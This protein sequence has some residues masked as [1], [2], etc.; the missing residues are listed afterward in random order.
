MEAYLNLFEEVIRS[1]ADTVG[2]EVALAQAKK[3]GLGVSREG[4]IVSC[5]GNPQLVL[6]RLIRS[7]TEGG[8]V[9]SLMACRPLIDEILANPPVEQPDEV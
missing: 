6:L 3:A 5:A 9:A 8:N 4:H 7:F 2:L 1:Q